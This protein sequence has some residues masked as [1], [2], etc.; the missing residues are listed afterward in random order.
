MATQKAP[1][2]LAPIRLG[3]MLPE[4]SYCTCSSVADESMQEMGEV[5]QVP[6]PTSLFYD[7][8]RSKR[9]ILG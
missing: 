7:Y 9:V 8:M 4:G 2:I 3:Q 6:H 1:S 5:E